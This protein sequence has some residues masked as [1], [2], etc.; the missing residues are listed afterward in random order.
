MAYVGLPVF[1]A[2]HIAFG[3]DHALLK[4]HQPRKKH[5]IT[6]YEITA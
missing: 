6:T 2:S 5:Q 4:R 1:N 3:A